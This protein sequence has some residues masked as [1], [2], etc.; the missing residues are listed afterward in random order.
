M[1]GSRK[2]SHSVARRG[3]V[4]GMSDEVDQNS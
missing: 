4:A 3:G 2:I 1:V